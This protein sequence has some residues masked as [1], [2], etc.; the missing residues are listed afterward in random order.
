MNHLN[1][2]LAPL[3]VHVALTLFVGLRTISFRIATVMKGETKLQ[4][5]ALNSNNWPPHVKKWGNNFDNQ[6][7]VPTVW[8]ALSALIVA[9]AKIDLAFIILSWLFVASRLAHSYI[10]TGSNFIRYRMYAFLAGFAIL[11]FMWAWFAIRL[12]IIG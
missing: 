2:L 4:D 11:M 6:F 12:F 1:W 8:Y 7:D 10:H 9:T 5:I 3:F